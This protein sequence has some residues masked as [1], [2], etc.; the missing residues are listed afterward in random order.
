MQE[1][2]PP[3]GT[4]WRMEFD[5]HEAIVVEVGGGL[6][7]YRVG[8][9]EIIDGYDEDEMSPGSAGQI[10]APWPNRIR[11]GR[12]SFGGTTHQL[13]LSEPEHHNAMHGLVLWAPW[14]LVER[15]PSCVTLEYVLPAQPG[16]PWTL[17]L[18]TTWMLGPDGLRAEHTVTNLSKRAAPFGMG[19][20]PYLCLPG[21]TTDD[22]VLTLPARSRLLSDGRCLPVGAARVYGDFDFTSP[23][24]L[25][26]ATLDTTFGDVPDG[27]SEARISS[28]DGQHSV[29]VW[30]D[31]SFR[32]W[33]VYTGDTLPAP[34]TRRSLA[35]EPMTCPPDA[36]AS[37]RDLIRLEPAGSWHGAWGVRTALG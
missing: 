26:S 4:Q 36:F 12:Y 30:A 2:G 10:L 14:R 37:G 8:G 5:D 1:I 17:R 25:G 29:T 13:A 22:L 24:R 7:T 23:R 27:G 9:Q 20:H 16:Y 35:V 31:G 18:V 21:L 32:W 19:A 28:T 3:S 6:R 34:R 15:T 33:Q 11:D